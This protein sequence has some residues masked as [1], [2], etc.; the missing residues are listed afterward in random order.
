[1]QEPAKEGWYATTA[2]TTEEGGVY[3]VDWGRGAEKQGRGGPTPSSHSEAARRSRGCGRC[4]GCVLGDC[5]ACKHCSDKPKVGGRGVT[6]HRSFEL[7]TPRGEVSRG[8]VS[9]PW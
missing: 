6:P 2:A 3:G 7:Y 8:T 5:G 9:W 1:M 4:N